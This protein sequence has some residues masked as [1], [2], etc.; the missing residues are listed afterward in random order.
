MSGCLTGEDFGV[1]ESVGFD[2]TGS[3]RVEFARC[4]NVVW[5]R[6]KS[7]AVCCCGGGGCECV[8]DCLRHGS[9]RCVGLVL[10]AWHVSVDLDCINCT[11]VYLRGFRIARLHFPS[12]G[13][14]RGAN[15]K[16]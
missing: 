1:R 13:I 12:T 7:V 9:Q 4:W 11:G 16:I 5:G 10:R 8:A 3:G 2:Q 6:G 14:R 15:L